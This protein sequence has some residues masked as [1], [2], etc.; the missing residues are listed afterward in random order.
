MI[1]HVRRRYVLPTLQ[2]YPALKRLP[3]VN[4]GY[5]TALKINLLKNEPSWQAVGS[6]NLH[7]QF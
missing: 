4:A 7:I 3:Q 5:G 2:L 1:H 6:S